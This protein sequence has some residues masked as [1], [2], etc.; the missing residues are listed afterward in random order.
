MEAGP[1]LEKPGGEETMTRFIDVY[2]E[3][4]DVIPADCVMRFHAVG[5]PFL[6]KRIRYQPD[7]C[8]TPGTWRVDSQHSD[9]SVQPAYGVEV[10]DSGAGTATLI[11]G[12][13][14]GLRLH[15][16]DGATT[17]IAEPYLLLDARALID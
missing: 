11:Y 6:V 15:R 5:E 14:F 8:P 9:G 13:D 17:T 2:V 1:L 3:S 4:N 16:E 7:D 10:D 12:A